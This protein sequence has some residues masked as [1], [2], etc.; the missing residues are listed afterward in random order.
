MAPEHSVA[1]GCAVPR[2]SKVDGP[3]IMILDESS[4]K[5]GGLLQSRRLLDA[6]QQEAPFTETIKWQAERAREGAVWLL[7][8]AKA[9]DLAGMGG[10][11]CVLHS[12]LIPGGTHNSKHGILHS[13]D[14]PGFPHCW[15]LSPGNAAGHVRAAQTISPWPPYY[16]LLHIGQLLRNACWLGHV[17]TAC[18]TRY[19][20]Q[21]E[22]SRS[23]HCSHYS[24]CNSQAIFCGVNKGPEILGCCF[25]RSAS[26]RGTMVT[27]YLPPY[28]FAG[29]P[30]RRAGESNF[31]R[32][33]G[34][35][36]ND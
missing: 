17:T 19:K 21:S 11:S 12:R 23:S 24:H 22:I 5:L 25:W 8:K 7:W 33:Y 34:S 6:V 9:V 18:I 35:S 1:Q 20:M 13:S 16:A 3:S 36:G 30:G 29:Y 2:C 14:S 28:K 10:S 32:G 4:L 26:D 31:Y 27:K 15:F